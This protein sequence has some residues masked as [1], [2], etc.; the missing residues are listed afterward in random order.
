MRGGFLISHPPPRDIHF[1][2]KPSAT[3]TVLHYYPST[4]QSTECRGI[5]HILEIQLIQNL[6]ES[7]PD[8]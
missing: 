6:I 4:K 3:G 5:I 7:F 1:L 8:R 2:I